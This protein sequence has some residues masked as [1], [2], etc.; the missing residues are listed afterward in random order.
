ME[1]MSI[2]LAGVRSAPCGHSLY[3]SCTPQRSSSFRITSPST[4]RYKTTNLREDSERQTDS[5]LHLH[6][7]LTQAFWVRDSRTRQITRLRCTCIVG[8]FR[9]THSWQCTMWSNSKHIFAHNRNL[10]LVLEKT[11]L[12][13]L[14]S[15]RW[16]KM[17]IACWETGTA[18]TSSRRSTWMGTS[19]QARLIN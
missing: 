3:S 14:S 11:Q 5:I 2:V 4:P 18:W 1:S 10:A 13:I 16:S 12:S 6:W 8:A 15:K 17:S 7:H 9:R 19:A